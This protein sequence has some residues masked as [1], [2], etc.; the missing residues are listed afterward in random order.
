LP[1]I[2]A[3]IGPI[4]AVVDNGKTGVLVPPNNPAALALAIYEL[5]A[6]EGE[7]K[8]MGEAARQLVA[9]EYTWPR[10]IKHTSQFLSQLIR[11]P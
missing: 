6:N 2:A 5:L 11:T 3:D 10:Q 4:S 8:R 9:Q 1:V 7:L